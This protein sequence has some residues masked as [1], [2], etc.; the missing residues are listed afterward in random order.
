MKK[1]ILIVSDSLVMGGLEKCLINVCDNL[2]YS[3]YQ[4][5]LYLSNEGRALLPKLNKH[6]KLLPDSPY[7]NT[8]YN[9]SVFKSIKQ[10]L[11]KGKLG[12]AWYRFIRFLRIR[13]KDLRFT[14]RDWKVMQ[15][16]M[17]DIKTEYD[18]AIGFAEGTSCYYV[19]EMVNAKR[20][21]GFI[22]T[23]LKMIDHNR[24]LDDKAF[25]I[26]DAVV[27]V[28]ENSLNSLIELHPNHKDKFKCIKVSTLMDYDNIER[29]SRERNEIE[30]DDAFKVVSVGRLV[31]LKGFHLC[32][33]ALKKLI[34]DGL[35]VK[36]YVVGEGPYR[37][38]IENLIEK[39][40]LKDKFVL[41]GNQPNPYKYV[42]SADVCV[43]P[44]SYEGFGIVVLEQKYLNKAVVV[45]NIP[46]YREM[47]KDGYNGLIVERDSDSIYKAV[48]TLVSDNE[49]CTTLAYNS[50]LGDFTNQKIIAQL[51]N[52]ID[53]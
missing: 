49:L 35:N 27:T 22:H 24:K 8:V 20:K 48:K 29:L 28:S 38:E 7:F 12:F 5:D 16:T 53:S 3:K 31:E 45:S 6:V 36:W 23:D 52:L 10:L 17:L 19:A 34:D 14:F 32:V 51:E 40:Q 9:L 2:D 30:S 37:S 15:K 26:L 33:Y 13:F 11:K 25:G 4:V 41:L 43:Q 44:S 21:I 39:Y 1:K 18:V 50:I 42:R 46:S 47:I